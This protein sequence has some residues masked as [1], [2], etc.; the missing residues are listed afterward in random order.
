[1]ARSSETERAVREALRAEG[2]SRRFSI[3][4]ST[5]G[6]L[7]IK[8]AGGG[9]VA[10]VPHSPGDARWLRNLRGDIKRAAKQVVS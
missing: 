2:V 9:I 5:R 8:N 1:M 3:V 7:L 6:H 4:R 10:V